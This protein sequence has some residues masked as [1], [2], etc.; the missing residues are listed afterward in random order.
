MSFGVDPL[1]SD[2]TSFP[3]YSAF[4]LTHRFEA[5]VDDTAGFATVHYSTH[6]VL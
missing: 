4:T 1:E 5:A 3:V 2:L 6:E